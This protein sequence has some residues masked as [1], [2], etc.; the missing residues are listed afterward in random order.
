[1]SKKIYLVRHAQS[2]ANADGRI[3][4]WL[5]SPLSERGRQQA[6]CLA[7]KL[8][9]M[10]SF[11][12]MFSSPL[13]RAAETARIIAD[14][15]NCPLKFDDD[16]REYNMGPITG[17]TVA[18]IKE[19]FPERYEAFER[20]ELLPHLPGEEGEAAFSE[21]VR[22]CMDRIVRQVPEGQATLVVAHGGSLNACLINWLGIDQRSRR[23]F[24]FYNASISIV[25]VNEVNR[26]LISLNDICHLEKLKQI[27]G[28]SE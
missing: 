27:G 23:P 9:T 2:L 11:Q 15:L 3:Q 20:N 12:L 7:D 21:R 10:A 13:Q 26:R 8:S 18:E 22:R 19:R 24:S 28:S 16:L 6:C 17:L 14:R 4:G 1:M 25:A 5:D